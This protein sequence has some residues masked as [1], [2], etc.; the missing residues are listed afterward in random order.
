PSRLVER[1]QHYFSTYKLL[2]GELNSV[3]LGKVYGSEHAMEVVEA[4]IADYEETFAFG[5]T[6]RGGPVRYGGVGPGGTA[7]RTPLRPSARLRGDGLVRGSGGRS[8]HISRGIE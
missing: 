4:A 8:R 2:P 5:V 7:G 6:G 3:Q 1:L